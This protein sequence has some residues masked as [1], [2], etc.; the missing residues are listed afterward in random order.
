MDAQRVETVILII[1]NVRWSSGL[2]AELVTRKLGF[3]AAGYLTSLFLPPVPQSTLAVQCEHRWGRR[4]DPLYHQV[5]M[6]MWLALKVTS[7]PLLMNYSCHNGALLSSSFYL[8]PMAICSN[9]NSAGYV[10]R[11]S[12]ASLLVGRYTI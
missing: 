7:I 9:H 2:H 3:R 4:L 12:D 11:T 1:T 6:P 8:Q 10:W 5:L